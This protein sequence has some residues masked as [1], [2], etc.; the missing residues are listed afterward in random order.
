MSALASDI[1]DERRPLPSISSS[2]SY[3]PASNA[4]AYS[5]QYNP[6][7]NSQPMG[8]VSSSWM[9]P[10]QQQQ[11]QQQYHPYHEQPQ[12]PTTPQKQSRYQPPFS[13]P[14]PSSIC[15]CA[16]TRTLLSIVSDGSSSPRQMWNGNQ[17]QQ[18]P[19]QIPT[20]LDFSNQQQ[21]QQ[22]QQRQS[23]PSTQYPQIMNQTYP[24]N[25]AGTRNVHR[26]RTPSLFVL[27][28]PS[29]SNER[30]MNGTWTD[31]AIIS[32]GNKVESLPSQWSTTTSS[33]H[34]SSGLSSGN[35]LMSTSRWS[36]PQSHM[37]T[38]GIYMPY[39]TTTATSSIED[40]NH[41]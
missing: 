30:W 13:K 31:P 25:N 18:Y 36:Q 38:N 32:H 35:N 19:P 1:E 9:M 3:R 24:A 29:G 27:S 33:P 11:Q 23:S 14:S 4:F 20:R 15:T 10:Q 5:L 6:T 41:P 39:S 12:Q 8:Q 34:G 40:R 7:T 21:Q 17:S 37:L 28:L 16:H 2:H 26:P 22:Q